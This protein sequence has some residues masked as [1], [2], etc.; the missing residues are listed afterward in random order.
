M[1]TFSIS[2]AAAVL[3]LSAHTLRY[4]ERDGLLE[5]IARSVGRR[6]YDETDLAW[7]RFIQRLRATGMPMR[8]I[9]EYARL[10]REGDSTLSARMTLLEA[11]LQLLSERE[12]ELAKHKQALDEKLEVYRQ[13]Q[14]ARTDKGT[15]HETTRNAARRR[16]SAGNGNGR[17]G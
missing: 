5:P 2:E 8:Q 7:L 11:H 16:R 12:R 17:V 10:R 6:R 4:Y 3:G 13:M 15:E 14:S 1:Q 9:H